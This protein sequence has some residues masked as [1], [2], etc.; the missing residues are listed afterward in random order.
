MHKLSQ[1][2]PKG[3]GLESTGLSYQES[4]AARRRRRSMRLSILVIY[5]LPGGAV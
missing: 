5:L 2:L 3:V 1:Q 4:Q